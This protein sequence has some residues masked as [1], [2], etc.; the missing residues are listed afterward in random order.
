MDQ[1]QDL[2]LSKPIVFFDGGCPLCQRE[3]NHYRRIDHQQN[4]SW[5]DIARERDV[6]IEYSLSYDSAMQQLHAVNTAGQ[7]VTGLDAFLLIWENIDRYRFLK[8][9][10]LKLR[11]QKALKIIYRV[12][13]K[14]RYKRRCDSRCAIEN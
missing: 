8:G 7:V 5:I 13:A 1:Q 2:P 11:L 3:V 10:I 12:F 9:F 6:L 4:I 14:W